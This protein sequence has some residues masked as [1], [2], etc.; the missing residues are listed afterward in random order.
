MSPRSARAEN[1]DLLPELGKRD[2]QAFHAWIAM[3]IEEL[4]QLT[5]F[6]MPKRLFQYAIEC[7]ELYDG[8]ILAEA[9]KELETGW[10]DEETGNG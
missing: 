4:R 6:V 2:D 9:R 3:H 5:Q 8:V 7:V 10:Y 1:L